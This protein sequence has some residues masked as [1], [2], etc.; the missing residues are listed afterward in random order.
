MLYNKELSSKTAL[1][2]QEYYRAVEKGNLSVMYSRYA[3]LSSLSAGGID[4]K[5]VIRAVNKAESP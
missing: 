1:W 5:L 4:P 2:L 3:A